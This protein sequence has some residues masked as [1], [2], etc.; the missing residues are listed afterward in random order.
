MKTSCPTFNAC[1]AVAA[2]SSSLP[3]E[4]NPDNLEIIPI[5]KRRAFHAKF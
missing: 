5:F 4:A 2:Q 1:K 3:P